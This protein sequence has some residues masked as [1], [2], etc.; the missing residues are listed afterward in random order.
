MLDELN[1]RMEE[2]RQG[3]ARFHKIEGMLRQL[4]DQ[5]SVLEKRERELKTRLEKENE[6]VEKLMKMSLSSMLASILGK[7]AERL[8]KEEREALEAKVCYDACKSELVDVEEQIRDLTLERGRYSRAQAEYDR[9]F[10]EKAMLLRQKNSGVASSI[11]ELDEKIGNQEAMFKELNEAIDAGERCLESLNSMAKSLQ[12]AASW[13]TWDMLGGGLISD[14]AKHSH[15]DDANA[16]ARQT[17]NLLRRFRT[18][19]ADVHIG[20]D[21]DVK[22]SDFAKFADF[23]FDGLFAD[24]FVQD[25]IRDSQRRVESASQQVQEIL[26]TLKRRRDLSKESLL[27]HRR[28]LQQIVWDA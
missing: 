10:A 12:S 9:L 25:K 19:L 8:N 3:I 16:T 15:I 23:F 22:I 26:Y 18:E 7:K 6:D 17:Q 24:W 14:M 5:R 11:L 27:K 28:A 2:A 20:A 4:H 13:G 1:K 21:I